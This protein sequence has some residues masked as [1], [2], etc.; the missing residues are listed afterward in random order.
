MSKKIV[1]KGYA[2]A[3]LFLL[4][5]AVLQFQ[6]K[7]D[8]SEPLQTIGTIYVDDDAECPGHGTLSA[9]YCSI[10]YAID[11]ADDGDDI[12]LA[13]G[14]YF[15][16]ILIDKE[17]TLDWHG[18]DINGSDTGI[19][20]INGGGIGIVVLIRASDVIIKQCS[21]TDSGSTDLDAGIYVG[22]ESSDVTILNNEIKNCYYG[23]WIKRYS[24]LETNHEI[25]G[26]IIDNI[27]ADG[28][29]ISLSDG[30]SIYNNIITN[31]GLHGIQ[32]LDCNENRIKENILQDSGF[33]LVV[34]VGIE[35]EVELN[36]CENNSEY[37]FVVVNTQKTVITNNNFLNN[38]VGQ[39][40]WINSLGDKWFHNYWGRP[41]LFLHIVGGLLRGADISFPWFKIELNPS[42]SL[43]VP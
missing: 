10:Q 35:N 32:L 19:P 17:I 26:N 42:S 27:E 22:E 6:V 38:G 40:T 8:T 15:E 39:A 34:D 20:V 30:N 5:T 3:L 7:G 16:N 33:G 2:V 41:M 37:G 31:C 28:I 12:K 18:D 36:T 29:I 14:E 1:R 24:V 11:N 21:I 43:N 4:C 13:S 23:V 25:R 9:S